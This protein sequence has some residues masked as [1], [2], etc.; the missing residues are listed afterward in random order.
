MTILLLI[1]NKQ[2]RIWT[3]DLLDIILNK[4]LINFE[5][6]NDQFFG[7]IEFISLDS[8]FLAFI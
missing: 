7:T 1:W 3:S 4:K 8:H 6:I 2:I 5:I